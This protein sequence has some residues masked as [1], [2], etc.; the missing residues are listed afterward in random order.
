M[1][2]FNQSLLKGNSTFK[3]GNSLV[4]ITPA[5]DKDYWL[6]RVHLFRNQYVQAFPKFFTLGIGFAIEDDWNTN[7]PYSQTAEAL[8]SHI[9]CNKKY[10]QIT[11]ERA[12]EAITLLSAA[13]ADYYL[14]TK[15]SVNN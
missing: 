13:C 4:A 3:A 11:K 6:F 14:Q 2:E 1:V 12:I 15:Q 8:Y 7:L 5:I 9:E 10:D